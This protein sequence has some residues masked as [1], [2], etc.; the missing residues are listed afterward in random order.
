MGLE[1]H[2]DKSK[3]W[4]G[5][6]EV[7]G[8]KISRSLGVEIQGQIPPRLSQV[9]DI[10]FERSRAKAQAALERFQI[11]AKKRSKAEGI[12]QTIHEIRT[13]ER[14]RSVLLADI[15]AR[16]KVLPRRRPLSERYVTQAESRVKR[17]L[18]LACKGNSVLKEMAQIPIL[19]R[20]RIRPD[21]RRARRFGEDLQQHR[22]LPSLGL[23]HTAQGGRACRESVRR[24]SST[25]RS[26]AASY[27]SHAACS[28]SR[29]RRVSE[30]PRSVIS[31][32]SAS[33]GLHSH[34]PLVCR[35]RWSSASR[36][37]APRAS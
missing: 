6:I 14:V 17:F 10:V 20:S 24:H 21:D 12:I 19:P 16:W 31:I 3:W 22:D 9:G 29:A 23:P 27:R 7:N 1:I 32:P 37:I 4:Y 15:V 11:D 13:S 36:G 5:R 25:N 18:T 34:S 26:R 2:R 35:W 30:K 8:R 33:L 28:R